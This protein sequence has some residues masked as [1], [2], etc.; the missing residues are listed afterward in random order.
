Q[1]IP[2]LVVQSK[3]YSETVTPYVARIDPETMKVDVLDLTGGSS[4]NYVGGVLVHSNGFVYAVARS[5]LYKIDP[6]SFTVQNSVPLPLLP[7]S[8][9]KEN[10]AMAY[11]GI[12]AIENG[13]FVLKGWAS[14]GGGESAF[15]YLLRL[16]PNNLA[17]KA[18]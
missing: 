15:G 17:T 2:L 5:V 6:S 3:L 9:G 10:E 14:T 16:D 4:V 1:L 12:V 13:D 8:S 18:K 7:D 11:N